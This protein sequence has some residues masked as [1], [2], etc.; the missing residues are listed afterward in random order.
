MMPDVTTD[1]R[2]TAGDEFEGESYLASLSDLMVGMLFV[3]ILMLMAFALTYRTA[4]DASEQSNQQLQ[5]ELNV[6]GTV[7]TF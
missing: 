5:S 7:Q 6:L 4:Q 2:E 1:L 3:F